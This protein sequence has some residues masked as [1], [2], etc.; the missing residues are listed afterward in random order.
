MIRLQRCFLASALALPLLYGL[1]LPADAAAPSNDR[2]GNAKRVTGLNYSDSVDASE[3]TSGRADPVDCANNASVWYR[4]T[5][6][7]TRTVNA[8]TTGSSYDTVLGVYTGRPGAFQ[9][10]ACRDDSP[11]GTRSGVNFEAVA[12]VTYFF[13]VAA[14]CGNGRDGEAYA[15]PLKLQFNVTRPLRVQDLSIADQASV[16]AVDGDAQLTLSS[17]CNY[18]TPYS[19]LSVRLRQRVAETYVAHAVTRRRIGCETSPVESLIAMVPNGDIAFIEGPATASA[20]LVVCHRATQTCVGR[21]VENSVLLS[22][23]VVG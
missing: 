18:A 19:F 13:M 4:F 3:A 15:R 11:F 23:P 6:A 8:N 14:C 22:Y 9:K 20:E 16:D 2:F 10:V 1:A 7:V 17:R 21:S 5:P 12:G